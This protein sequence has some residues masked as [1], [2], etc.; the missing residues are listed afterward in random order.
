MIK[1]VT[2]NSVLGQKKCFM[3][4]AQQQKS[5]PSFLY[6][7]FPWLFEAFPFFS[8]VFPVIAIQRK[9]LVD[10][11]NQTIFAMSSK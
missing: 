4:I 6:R 9:N 2:Q 11:K 7:K 8:G 3:N 1:I 10:M 5:P